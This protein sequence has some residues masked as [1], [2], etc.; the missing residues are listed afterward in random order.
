MNRLIITNGGSGVEAI[1][2]A[3]IDGEIISWDD[4]LHEGPVPQ[5]ENLSLLSD[6]RTAFLSSRMGADPAEIRARFSKR[7][8]LLLS[9]LQRTEVVCWFEHD[10]YDQLQVWQILA[11]LAELRS[12]NPQTTQSLDT[13]VFSYICDP[14][15][16]GNQTSD[17]LQKQFLERQVISEAM[18][19]DAVKLWNAF[20]NPSPHGLAQLYGKTT[21]RFADQSIRRWKGL[22]PSREDGL[23]LV[24]RATLTVLAAAAGPVLFGT[25]FQAVS[26]QEEAIFMGDTSF[27]WALKRMDSG[28]QPLVELEWGLPDADGVEL[29]GKTPRFSVKITPAGLKRL[30]TPERWEKSAFQARWVGGVHLTPN[31]FWTFHPE[32][33]D[34]EHRSSTEP[35]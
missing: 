24:E 3:E 13:T 22:F 35:N 25:L 15:F 4:V 21:L 6:Q 31:D 28:K 8:H 19:S 18:F 14:V 27:E 20:R 12:Q 16:V 9:A 26:E 1:A 17:Q 33:N 2:H 34:P 30:K 11:T 32:R 29:R 10:L 7:D 5:T 23:D